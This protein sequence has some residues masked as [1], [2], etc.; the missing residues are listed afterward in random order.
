MQ[1]D[2]VVIGSG[3]WGIA[4][5]I[6]L[7]ENGHRVR[8]WS[9]QR[10]EAERIRAERMN[11]AFLPGVEIPPGIQIIHDIAQARDAQVYVYAS[12]SAVIRSVVGSFAAVM[13]PD[14]LVVNVA[15]GLEDGTLLRLSQVIEQAAPGRRVGVLTGPSHAEEVSRKVPTACVAS[16]TDMK[17][18][19]DIQDIFMS[20][21]FRIYTNADIVGVEL[22]GAMKNV[23]AL[24]AGASDGMGF[25]DNTK[26]ALMTRG[27]YEMAR[28]GVAMGA[29][30]E[31]FG[32]LTG[33]GD[34]IVTCTSMHSRNRRA[35]ILLGQ[36]KSLAETLAEVRMVVEGVEASRAALHLAQK[37]GVDMPITYEINQALWH[38]KSPRQ[39]VMD[40][41]TR[42]KKLE[43][44]GEDA[45]LV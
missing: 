28:L 3:S 34:M 38:G 43:D 39:A 21:V 4:L 36:G 7:L 19:H 8:L 6:L 33:M 1:K 25:G 45:Y 29:K 40:L 14:A 13:P 9:Y 35:G 17:T 15:K 12:P 27:M 22:G 41:M 30:R 44:S 16:S 24:A 31:T 26:A 18:A 37:Y 23:I 11:A 42:D 2:I 32:G 10:E 5:S 20:P